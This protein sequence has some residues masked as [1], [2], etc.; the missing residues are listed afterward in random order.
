M[1]SKLL[2]FWSLV[3]LGI[4][5]NIQTR[6]TCGSDIITIKMMI[7]MIL[8]LLLLLLLLLIIIMIIHNSNNNNDNHINNNFNNN[9]CNKNNKIKM[10]LTIKYLLRGA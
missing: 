8:H 6:D 3:P 5:K 7:I 4:V 9:N 2:V 10:I 1:F